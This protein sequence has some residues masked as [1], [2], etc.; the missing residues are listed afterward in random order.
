MKKRKKSRQFLCGRQKLQGLKDICDLL[1]T[2][3]I[4]L[5]MY[6]CISAVMT[7][8]KNILS[9]NATSLLEFPGRCSSK[10][11]LSNNRVIPL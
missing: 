1:F 3:S 10:Y 9:E 7:G 4:P 11:L 8:K 2:L 5:S 6:I